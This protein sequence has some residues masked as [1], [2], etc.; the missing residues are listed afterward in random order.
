M[1]LRQRLGTVLLPLS[2]RAW[3]IARWREIW[4]WALSFLF[5]LS[6]FLSLIRGT[7]LGSMVPL[8]C[9]QKIDD[10]DRRP[11]AAANLQGTITQNYYR[12]IRTSLKH[13]RVDFSIFSIFSINE[14][15]TATSTGWS[16]TKT[17]NLSYIDTS[18]GWSQ[19]LPQRQPDNAIT[20][21]AIALM[22]CCIILLQVDIT[23]SSILVLPCFCWDFGRWNS[24]ALNNKFS[25]TFVTSTLYFLGFPFSPP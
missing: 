4:L 19:V 22:L 6:F 2:L 15:C 21:S 8:S 24:I 25:A 20:F 5:F 17:N 3:K 13:Y 18:G 11:F 16:A 12:S 7:D 10:W 14:L 1:S 9:T 23:D